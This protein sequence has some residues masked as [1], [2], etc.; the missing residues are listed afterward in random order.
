VLLLHEL[1]V[2]HD[3]RLPVRALPGDAAK[4]SAT[5]A[6]FSTVGELAVDGLLQH[7]LL[8][9]IDQRITEILNGQ[10]AVT[11]TLRCA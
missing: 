7:H 4:S 2:I 3:E 6:T 1:A 9:R 10:R 5:S 8:D 11:A